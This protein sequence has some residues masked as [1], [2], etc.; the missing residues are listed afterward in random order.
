MHASDTYSCSL[1]NTSAALNAIS[2][3]FVRC[4]PV[5]VPLTSLNP[6]AA[7]AM[8]LPDSVILALLRREVL[9]TNAKLHALTHEHI[10][11]KR[12]LRT[13]KYRLRQ[14]GITGNLYASDASQLH[15]YFVDSNMTSGPL[16]LPF[17]ADWHGTLSKLWSSSSFITI[18]SHGHQMLCI[19]LIELS[20]PGQLSC[21][22]CGICYSERSC[23]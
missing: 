15:R 21:Q 22:L 23:T 13:L 12:E 9:L 10:L 1:S 18:C 4:R 3:T 20:D 2:T 17:P 8:E 16:L 11:G 6:A 5:P 19:L 7:E 14:V